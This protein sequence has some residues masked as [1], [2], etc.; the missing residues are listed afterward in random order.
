MKI[1]MDPDLTT[2]AQVV[3][4]ALTAEGAEEQVNQENATKQ[5]FP[6]SFTVSRRAEQGRRPK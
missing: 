1:T 3:E 5:E 4:R 6:Q 2:Y